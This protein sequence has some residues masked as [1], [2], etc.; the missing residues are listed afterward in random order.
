MRKI[1]EIDKI[2]QLEK[3]VETRDNTIAIKDQLIEKLEKRIREL[4]LDI[5][6]IAIKSKGKTANL[7]SNNRR[8]T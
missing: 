5:K 4:E 8:K 7:H 2:Y 3:T 1:L 6:D